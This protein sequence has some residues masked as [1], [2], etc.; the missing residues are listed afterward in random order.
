MKSFSQAWNFGALHK[1]ERKRDGELSEPCEPSLGIRLEVEARDFDVI[2]P[3]ALQRCY[4]PTTTKTIMRVMHL[5]G[6]V[7]EPS[8]QNVAMASEL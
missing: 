7:T 4:R 3:P 2:I 6:T 1:V 5:H 8:L